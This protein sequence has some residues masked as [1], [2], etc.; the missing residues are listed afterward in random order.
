MPIRVFNW[1]RSQKNLIDPSAAMGAGFIQKPAV[2]GAANLIVSDLAAFNVAAL[3]SRLEQAYRKV[4]QTAKRD[5]RLWADHNEKKKCFDPYDVGSLIHLII[6]VGD[7][8][9]TMPRP[10]GFVDMFVADTGRNADAELILKKYLML[11]PT[12]PRGI[13]PAQK[14]NRAG[15]DNTETKWSFYWYTLD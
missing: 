4:V 7:A 13:A 15:P 11:V 12:D 14:L 6:W 1:D 8:P 10:V 3:R 5:I 9:I 2:D